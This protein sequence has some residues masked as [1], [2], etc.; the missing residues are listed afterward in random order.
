ML[1]RFE[2][3]VA[4]GQA[5]GRGRRRLVVVA[6]QELLDSV[7]EQPIGAAAALALYA[8][9]QQ[10]EFGIGS[11]F[12]LARIMG[13]DQLQEGAGRPLIPL[14][15]CHNAHL[16]EGA[17]GVSAAVREEIDQASQGDEPLTE[18]PLFLFVRLDLPVTQTEGSQVPA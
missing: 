12:A 16:I 3:E 8:Q 15:H 14:Q 6:Q 9:P 10:G 1:P 13:S 18:E 5:G 17:G 11:G 4:E 2:I 7:F